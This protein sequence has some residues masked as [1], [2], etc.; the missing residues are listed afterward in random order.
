M[1]AL[2]GINASLSFVQKYN[3]RLVF[4]VAATW[5]VIDL[6][7]W[8]RFVHLSHALRNGD[9]FEFISRETV[10]LRCAIVFTMS[11]L[12]AYLLIFKLRQVFRNYPLFINLL[13]KTAILLS[14][15]LLMNFLLHITYSVFILNFT[16]GHGLH[17]FFGKATSIVWVLQHSLGWVILFVLSQMII[18]INEKYSPGIFWAILI[19]KYIQ[20]KV[21]K[22]II[23]F[24]DLNDSTSIAEKL[25][26]TDNFKFIRDFIYYVSVALLEYNGRIYQYVG[27]E[28]VVSWIYKPQNVH[29]CLDAL[30]MSSRL[31][32]RSNNYFHQR[33]GF[34]PEFKVGIHVGE[35]TVGEIG[36]IKKDIAM[37]GDT[38]N[39]TARICNS[40]SELGTKYIVSKDFL[41][42]INIRWPIESL[43]MVELKGKSD[44]MELFALKM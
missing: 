21:E 5:T 6:A 44:S 14:A 28:I 27:D 43:G 35:V 10:L 41:E 15:S 24:I 37:S 29:K 16:I 13:V 33:Y 8:V 31:L 7:Y 19:G 32:K 40:S 9:T 2:K 42:N 11:C 1:I 30:S 22:R 20:P 3:F 25:G 38:M 39:T 18:E 26:S 34:L 4:I 17:S 23:M 12:M 36:L